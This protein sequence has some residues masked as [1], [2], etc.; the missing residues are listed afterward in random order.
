MEEDVLTMEAPEETVQEPESVETG[1]EPERPK[2]LE[3]GE[4]LDFLRQYPGLDPREIPKSVWTEV[5]RGAP[6][7]EAYGRHERSCLQARNRELEQQLAVLQRNERSRS[8]SVGSMRSHGS[9][10]GYDEF[11]AGFDEA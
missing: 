3:D 10:G 4:A 9:G 7:A 2:V 1:F 8:L 6:L 11:M 5:G